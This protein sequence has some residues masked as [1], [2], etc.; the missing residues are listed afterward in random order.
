MLLAAGLLTIL[1]G[2]GIWRASERTANPASGDSPTFTDWSVSYELQSKRPEGLGLLFEL[3]KQHVAS[4]RVADTSLVMHLR[5]N[6]QT[7]LF[8]GENF[9]LKEEEFHR[10]LEKVR[11]GNQLIVSAQQLDAKFKQ[12]FFDETSFGWMFNPCTIIQDRSEKIFTLC[13]VY[14]MDTLAE[15][16]FM[17]EH[18]QIM[19]STERE[20]SSSGYEVLQEAHETPIYVK[21]PVGKG[22]VA[23]HVNPQFFKNYQLVTPEGFA[24]A[25][26]FLNEIDQDQ[27]LVW[28]ALASLSSAE[29]A[30]Q[31]NADTPPEENHFLLAFLLE[32]PMLRTAFLW[33]LVGILLFFV[34]GA[35]RYFPVVPYRAETLNHSLG[36]A[37]TIQQIFQKQRAPERLLEVMRSNVRT[38]VNRHLH[39][40]ITN[41]ERAEVIGRIREKTGLSEARIS[42]L[43]D[44]LFDRNDQ[45]VDDRFLQHVAQTVRSFYVD[46]GI[47]QPSVTQR[48]ARRNQAIRYAL[49]LP[50]GALLIGILLLLVGTYLLTQ[51]IGIGILGWPVGV[52]AVLVAIRCFTKPYLQLGEKH[53]TVYRWYGSTEVI[54]QQ[55]ILRIAQRQ[56]RWF[57]VLDDGTQLRIE[58]G[59]ISTF[60]RTRWQEARHK[61]DLKHEI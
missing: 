32:H 11:A 30:E 4:T 13:S 26:N 24:Y 47:I 48:L 15:R 3:A 6:P 56:K 28:L 61:F 38:A 59:W 27:E 60:D 44:Q 31:N 20:D 25:K 46:T 7:Y 8:V 5:S 22:T 57:L 54:D 10:L 43:L 58:G 19:E 52:L 2:I 40:D 1:V 39:I 17:I 12:L 14:Q 51:G 53:W 55:T 35:K 18:E 49:W 37:T 42:V 21:F 41:G 9:V 45:I 29:L 50:F 36:F 23:I 16:M 34:F 33:T